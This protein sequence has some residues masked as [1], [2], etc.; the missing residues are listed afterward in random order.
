MVKPGGVP[1]IINTSIVDQPASR[2][3]IKVLSIP[4]N[5]IAMELGS[6]KVGNMVMLGC[7]RPGHRTLSPKRPLKR[8]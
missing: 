7:P 2:T 1:S 3:D 5:E 4:V 8:S 6:V